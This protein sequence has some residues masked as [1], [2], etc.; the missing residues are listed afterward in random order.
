MLQQLCGRAEWQVP[1]YFLLQA[2]EYIIKLTFS[3]P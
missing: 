3:L 2:R 1:T